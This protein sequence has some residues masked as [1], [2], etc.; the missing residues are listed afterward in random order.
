M[1]YHPSAHFKLL[2]RGCPYHVW[3]RSLGMALSV[4]CLG[5]ATTLAQGDAPAG[6]WWLQESPSV[7]AKDEAQSA[8]NQEE[9]K[10]APPKAEAKPAP[11]QEDP[12]PAPKKEEP[13]PA[14]KPQAPAQPVVK[15]EPMKEQA[16]AQEAPKAPAAVAPAPASPAVAEPIPTP[17][18]VDTPSAK[19]AAPMAARPEPGVPAPMLPAPSAPG[20]TG[21]TPTAA[22]TPAVAPVPDTV[23]PVTLVDDKFVVP[24][25]DVVLVYDSK[26]SDLIPLEQVRRSM[27]ITL[28]KTEKGWTAPAIAPAGSKLVTLTLADLGKLDDKRFT[29]SAVQVISQQIVSYYNR[30]GIIGVAV[31]PHPG[32]VG[33]QGQDL[34][35]DTQN[36]RMV[37]RIGTVKEIR[38]LASGSRIPLEDRINNPAHDRIKRHAPVQDGEAIDKKAV[39]SYLGYVNRHPNRRVDVALSRGVEEGTVAL[40]YLVAENKP[41]LVYFQLTNTGTRATDPWRQRFGFNHSQLTN[42]DDIFDLQYTTAGFEDTHSVQTSYE[43][44]FLDV[45]GLRWRAFVNYSTY[46]ASDVGVFSQQFEGESWSGGGQLIYNL[47]QDGEFFLDAF[48]GVR[49][50][51]V[52]VNNQ[53]TMTR[54]RDDFFLPT[55]G[56]TTG[57][58]SPTLNA[59]GSV[60][61]EFN[62]DD[63]ANTDA[64]QVAAMG[65]TLADTNFVTLQWNTGLSFYLEPLLNQEAWSKAV[66]NNDQATLAHELSFSFEGQYGM[67]GRLPANYQRTA[68][69]LY[70][71]RGYAE[72]AAAGDSVLIG[73]LEYRF[74]IPRIFP[75]NSMGSVND[76]L[77][78]TYQMSRSTPY[79]RADWDLIFRGFLDVGRTFIN[80]ALPF[81]RENTLVGT[82]VG[83]ELLIKQNISLRMDWGI[84]LSDVEESTGT[85]VN[86]GSNR[87]HFIFTFLY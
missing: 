26:A 85:I 7:P 60:S 3:H 59:D 58:R 40:D 65:R 78:N 33:A 21:L 34:R 51:N 36:L 45:P 37:V 43:A 25:T 42:N 49:W 24:I 75:A 32:D 10:P 38:T 56:L 71:V 86:A 74:H 87:F 9:V 19:P 12:R 55:V 81:E 64:A 63:I 22:P 27:E 30:Q 5:L 82:G 72:S 17:V 83:L 1:K 13:P 73:R 44:L 8:P 80:D 70:T 69:G 2:D 61:L 79:G 52:K 35:Q 39:D 48:G 77:G 47:I 76:P 57:Y 68:G 54:G 16:P 31:G 20:R 50:D 46:T 11:K 53:T 84:A 4:G 15:T 66:V 67:D 14:G 18:S 6:A 23:Q 62:L 29:A 41:W 28:A